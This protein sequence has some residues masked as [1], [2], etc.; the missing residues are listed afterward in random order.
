MRPSKTYL[1]VLLL[2]LVMAG[3]RV[4]NSDFAGI[5]GAVFDDDDS[6]PG[7]WTDDDDDSAGRGSD[8]DDASDDDDSAPAFGLCY[9]GFT[10]G[11]VPLGTTGLEGGDLSLSATTHAGTDCLDAEGAYA[12]SDPAGAPWQYQV[13]QIGGEPNGFL[14]FQAVSFEFDPYVVVLDEACSCI[15]W[16]S[17]APGLS[18]A[19][20][21]LPESG[22]ATVLVSTSGSGEVGEYTLGWE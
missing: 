3:C 5:P 16:G 10:L 15:A 6:A 20:F 4:L 7:S 22:S 17:S 11:Y 13:W 14:L 2:L 9:G 19:T 12:A 8:D 1:G 18:I 21:Q